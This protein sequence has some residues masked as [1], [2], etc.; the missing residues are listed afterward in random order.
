MKQSVQSAPIYFL[1]SSGDGPGE[2]Q[3]AVA[4]ALK[5]FL[6]EADRSD[7][8][9]SIAANETRLGVLSATVRLDGTDA[10]LL[11]RAWEGTIQWVAKSPLRPNHRRTNWFIGVFRLPEVQSFSGSIV[12]AD[13]EFSSFRAGGPG[14]QH[15]NTTD[16]AVRAVHKPTGTV[17][18]ARNQRSQHRN[19]SA[20]LER[21]E[22]VLGLQRDAEISQNRRAE[23]RLHG[24]L[25]RGNPTR[26]FRGDAFKE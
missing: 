25:E 20:A 16:S 2:C 18:V 6:V 4:K 8:D 15:Q 12:L 23:N 19:K 9:I 13:V 22:H 3:L 21:L 11:A 10:E 1:V 14:G 5:Q 26:V 7:V 17:V 24:Q